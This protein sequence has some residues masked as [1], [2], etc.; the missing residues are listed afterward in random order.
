MKLIL[1][2]IAMIQIIDFLIIF[3]FN[4]FPSN[5]LYEKLFHQLHFF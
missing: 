4:Q 1:M 2:K 3:N 5:N